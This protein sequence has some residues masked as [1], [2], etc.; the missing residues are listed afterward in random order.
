MAARRKAHRPDPTAW[1]LRVDLMTTH[2]LLLVIAARR[3]AAL[4]PEVHRYF[5]D[6]YARLAHHHRRRGNARR[7]NALLARSL[8]H[9]HLGG[10]DPVPPRAALAMPVPRCPTFVEAIG[11]WP[12]DAPPA[13]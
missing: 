8:R 7:A 6:R 1:Q 9:W 13:A 10:G 11:F 3:N 12:D 2:A 4:R 5:A